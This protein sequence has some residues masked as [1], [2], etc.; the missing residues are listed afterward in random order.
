VALA[1]QEQEVVADLLFAERGR[2][3]SVM[4]AD[5]NRIADVG[6][7]GAGTKIAELDKLLEPGD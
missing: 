1:A 6:L 2:I 5:Q 7:A 4:A 3:R